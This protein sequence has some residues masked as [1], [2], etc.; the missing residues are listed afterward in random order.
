MSPPRAV[1]A[2]VAVLVAT[3]CA[4]RGSVQRAVDDIDTLRAEVA[5]LRQAQ[6][7][8]AAEVTQRLDELRA[9]DA[10]ATTLETGIR[11]SSDEITRLRARVET[12]EEELRQARTLASVPPRAPAPAIAPERAPRSVPSVDAAAEQLY[13][14]AFSAFR[15]REYGQAVLDFLDFIAKF[16]RHPLA[17]NAQYWIAEAYY[18]QRDYRQAITEFRKV[19]ETYPASSKAADALIKVGLCYNNLRDPTRARQTWQRVMTRYPST[20]AAAIAKTLMRGRSSSRR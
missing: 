14:A 15:S 2:M 8:I 11:Q 4:S 9:L 17:A 10:R 16:P 18:V 13:S 5:D 1:V 3:G 12:T 6:D 19:A 20:E 7:G